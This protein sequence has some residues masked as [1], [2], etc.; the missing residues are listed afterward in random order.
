[1]RLYTDDNDLAVH[2]D[3]QKAI[4]VLEQKYKQFHLALLS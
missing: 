4:A 3:N 1:M 2:R